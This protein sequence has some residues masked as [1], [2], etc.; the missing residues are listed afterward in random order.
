VT[1]E[2]KLRPL[3]RFGCSMVWRV[4]SALRANPVELTVKLWEVVGYFAL[5]GCGRGSGEGSH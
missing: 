2:A 5:S 1:T 3:A 4:L